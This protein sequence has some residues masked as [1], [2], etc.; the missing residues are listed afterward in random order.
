MAGGD[1][2]PLQGHWFFISGIT[3]G[4]R[5]K[6]TAV[7]AEVSNQVANYLEYDAELALAYAVTKNEKSGTIE[8][9]EAVANIPILLNKQLDARK[10]IQEI[11]KWCGADL[12]EFGESILIQQLKQK[13]K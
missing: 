13:M 4:V 10:K 6:K 11:A 1:I 9:A 3:K 5:E 8:K 2:E 12:K 7:G